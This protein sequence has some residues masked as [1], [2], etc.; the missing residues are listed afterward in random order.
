MIPFPSVPTDSLYKFKVIGGIFILFASVLAFAAEADSTTRESIEL[1][2]QI[3]LLKLKRTISSEIKSE[4]NRVF[5]ID[6][7]RI[8][9]EEASLRK[10]V[11]EAKWQKSSIKYVFNNKFYD[12]IQYRSLLLTQYDDAVL[13]RNKGVAEGNKLYDT[14]RNDEI[15][16][17]GK[18]DMI[19]RN[20]IFFDFIGGVTGLGIVIAA[21]LIAT[22]IK[23]WQRL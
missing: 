12:T 16:I 15:Q 3:D 14:I 17:K 23:Q 18:K 8:E 4:T 21:I 20:A 19:E 5:S 13:K 2:S 10:R 7:S 6:S 11:M 9:N 22:G 1:N